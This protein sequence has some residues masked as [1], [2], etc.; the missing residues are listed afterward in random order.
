MQLRTENGRQEIFD[1]IL[2][3]WRGVM[4][5]DR[6][7]KQTGTNLRL[8]KDDERKYICPQ[9]GEDVDARSTTT[10]WQIRQID[11]V[12]GYEEDLVD[13][14]MDEARVTGYICSEAC[15]W[16]GGYDW[17]RQVQEA[18]EEA[19]KET[20]QPPNFNFIDLFK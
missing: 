16:E 4:S 7:P 19:A 12:T 9:C 10:G 2:G 17:L 14:G 3:D 18:E 15:G 1:E 8:V 13:G 6:V 20:V 11:P 5:L